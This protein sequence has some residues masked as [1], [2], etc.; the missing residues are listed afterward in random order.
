M[1][2][3]RSFFFVCLGILALA[4]H[5]GARSAGAQPEVIA[6]PAK[7]WSFLMGPTS[8][9]SDGFLLNAD[10]GELWRVI[11]TKRELVVEQ[12]KQ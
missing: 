6:R 5:V 9:A 1:N 12:T 8:S 2:R 10:T 3:A 11:A 7:T 4:Y